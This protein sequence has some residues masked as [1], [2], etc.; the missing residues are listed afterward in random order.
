MAPD[1]A[2]PGSPYCGFLLSGKVM[3]GDKSARRANACAGVVSKRASAPYPAKAKLAATV[4][5]AA[6]WCSSAGAAAWLARNA[7]QNASPLP[8]VSTGTDGNAG[9]TNMLASPAL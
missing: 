1:A 3:G 7:Q 8:V 9:C 6:A 4:P 5:A 2:V